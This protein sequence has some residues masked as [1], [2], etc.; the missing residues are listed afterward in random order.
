MTITGDV[1]G[2]EFLWLEITGRCQL[3]C[4]HCYN[5]SGADGDAGAMTP[6]G[7]RRIITEAAEAGVRMVQFI[8]G[9]PTM[10]P[11]LPELIRHALAWDLQVEVYTN[12]VNIRPDVWAAVAL[13]G[14]SLATSF[15]TDDREQHRQITGRDTLRQIVMNIAQA[16]SAGIPLRVGMVRVLEGQ[17]ID[18][19]M[20]MLTGLGVAG[21]R[22]DRERKLGRAGDGGPSELCG[23]CGDG[24][25]A[26]LPDGSVTAC[27]MARSVTVGSVLTGPLY[28][29]LG[30]PLAAVAAS[31]RAQVSGIN[32]GN[33]EPF[34]S[35]C[36][37]PCDPQFCDPAGL[38][39]P[40][41]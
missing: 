1:R 31:I 15:Y 29:S 13:P 21:I 16:I 20:T 25:A 30:A 4:S 9:E 26:V 23:R 19:A 34:K 36:D 39:T 6:A 22:V 28:D 12:L 35:D 27:P 10:H 40:N 33:C 17:R 2:M 41:N 32:A 11:A 38:C 3:A 14:V 24:K 5:S 37:P 8:G 7:W 18:E